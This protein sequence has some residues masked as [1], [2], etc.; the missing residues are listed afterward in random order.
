MP[1]SH[2]TLSDVIFKRDPWELYRMRSHDR[3]VAIWKNGWLPRSETFIRNQIRAVPGWSPLKIGFNS[4]AAGLERA[5][6]APYP[7]NFLGKVAR[8][9]FG[10]AP[11]MDT[12][13]EMIRSFRCELIHAHFGSGGVNSLPLARR[14]GLPLITTFHG[15]DTRIYGSSVPGLE[16]RYQMGLRSLFKEGKLLL[17]ASRYL[18]DQLVQGGAPLGKTEVLYTGVPPVDKASA[19]SREGIIFV[20]RLIKIKGVHHLLRAAA[21]L[22]PHLRSTPITIVGD[23][24]ERAPLESLARDLGLHARFA[25][26]RSSSEIPTLL[27]RHRLFCGPSIPSSAGTRE[28]FGTVFLE[29][30]LQELPVV[31]Y[32]SGGVQE[33]VAHGETGLLVP[34]GDIKQLSHALQTVLTEDLLAHSMGTNGRRRVLEDFN[35]ERQAAHLGRIYE[36]IADHT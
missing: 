26:L 8:I 33:A 7:S 21:E 35:M 30:A 10:T 13:V 15:A 25:G 11:F 36:S 2:D 32:A 31:A 24:P 28:G 27:A 34:E 19:Q 16:R 1:T 14:T 22:P 9:S 6:F 23:G 18:A 12:Y 17:A 29:A 5:D 20:G 4:L 3:A